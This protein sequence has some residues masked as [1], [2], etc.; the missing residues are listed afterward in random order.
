MSRFGTRSQQKHGQTF[1]RCAPLSLIT[2]LGVL[3]GHPLSL[4]ASP[5][6]NPVEEQFLAHRTKIDKTIV[7]PCKSARRE[8]AAEIQKSIDACDC[9]EARKQENTHELAATLQAESQICEQKG[10]DA[11]DQYRHAVVSQ[12]QDNFLRFKAQVEVDRQ[13]LQ[14]FGFARTI[15]EME[16]WTQYGEKAQEKY[17]RQAQNKVIEKFFQS[18]HLKAESMAATPHLSS[19]RAV[20]LY[21]LF[22]RSGIKDKVLLDALAAAGRGEPKIPERAL[23]EEVT[24]YLERSNDARE[25]LQSDD[26]AMDMFNSMLD[27]AGWFAPELGPEISIA[28]D[29]TWIG[30]ATYT[31][32][33][34]EHGLY[35]VNRLTTLT[36]AQLK[37]LEPVTRRLKQDVDGLVGAKKVLEWAK[38]ANS[39]SVD[40]VRKPSD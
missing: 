36:E 9:T 33:K 29:A 35:E 37:G 32:G 6:G 13:I 40:F 20:S 16:S 4:C 5:Q 18:V 30:Y 38:G 17:I 19:E 31:W 3:L 12:A 26:D 21:N 28:K 34:K 2:A 14:N 24:K 27:V 22:K 10:A 7:E 39:N 25:V 15:D 8:K 23:W 11:L 1:C